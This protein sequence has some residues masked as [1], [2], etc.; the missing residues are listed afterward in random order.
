MAGR[1]IRRDVLLTGAAAGAAAATLAVSESHALATIDARGDEPLPPV[2][3]R[4][5][6]DGLSVSEVRLSSSA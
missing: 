3:K 6:T 5:L 4:K 2:P 1:A